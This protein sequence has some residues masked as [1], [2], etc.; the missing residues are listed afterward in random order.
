MGIDYEEDE[1]DFD[2][3]QED[4]EWP[5]ESPEETSDF[6]NPDMDDDDEIEKLRQNTYSKEPQMTLDDIL[7]KINTSGYDSLTDEEREFLSKQEGR[8]ILGFGK[9]NK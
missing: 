5:Y 9:F 7:D 8:K 4:P 3:A 2:F 1:D 6:A